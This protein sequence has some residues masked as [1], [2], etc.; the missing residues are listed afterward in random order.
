MHSCRSFETVHFAQGWS[1]LAFR[2][3]C[4]DGDDG[5]TAVSEVMMCEV[6]F[7]DRDPNA[8]HD[9]QPPVTWWTLTVRGQI[10]GVSGGGGDY[11]FYKYTVYV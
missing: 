6:K 10:C 1:C 2:F 9:A 3:L 11:S 8:R 7:S 4:E 5:F